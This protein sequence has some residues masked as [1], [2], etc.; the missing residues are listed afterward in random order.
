V[1]KDPQRAGCRVW[2]RL[3]LGAETTSL[4]GG[5]VAALGAFEPKGEAEC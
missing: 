4:Q 2:I 3:P 1:A 5:H